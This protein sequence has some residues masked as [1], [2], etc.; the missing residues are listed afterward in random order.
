LEED[1]I[2]QKGQGEKEMRKFIL[3]LLKALVNISSV[4]GTEHKIMLYLEK[5]MKR[6]GVKTKRY[7]AENNRFN[8]LAR[9]GKGYP[10]VC[11][12]THADTV[13][14][15]GDSISYAKFRGGILYG[16]GAC[17]AKASL[18]AMAAVFRDYVASKQKINGTLD[19]L[20][21]IDEETKS[22]EVHSVITQGYKCNYAIVGEPTN[23]DI[24]SYH[25]GQIF[26]DVRAKGRS[27]HSS[28]PWKGIN[29]IDELIDII[30]SI[31]RLIEDG[32]SI[33]G[34]GKQ[35]LNLGAIRGGDVANRVPNS[36]QALIDIRILPDRSTT[37][38]LAQM[39]KIF[40]INK[41]VSYRILKKVE[42][43]KLYRNS[44]FINLVKNEVRK[45]TG[46][47]AI[48]KGARFW[49]EAADFRN[50]LSAQTVVLG[51]GEAK[52]AHSENEF[53]K[54]KQV[55]QAAEIYSLIAQRLFSKG[56]TQM[57]RNEKC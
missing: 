47:R 26:L 31:R 37:D 57:R 44:P 9:Y 7:K 28:S 42:P 33:P 40:K 18:V 5:E 23:L 32:K 4:S 22:K 49:T 27:T 10:I 11:L 39:D 36:C 15:S 55:F 21:S 52:Q 41:N 8:L 48:P 16:L 20:I 30:I 19:F 2:L 12:N 34:I 3:H 38:I 25:M 24:I 46:K 13:P 50:E 14:P 6:W 1:R 45:V 53:V 35:T 29:A 51:P 17:D 43:M 54:L 56:C